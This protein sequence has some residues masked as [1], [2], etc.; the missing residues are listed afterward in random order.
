MHRSASRPVIFDVRPK[1]AILKGFIV[2]LVAF[3]TVLILSVFSSGCTRNLWDGALRDDAHE[4]YN[5]PECTLFT[6]LP[7]SRIVISDHGYLFVSDIIIQGLQPSMATDFIKGA[8]V[9]GSVDS[10]KEMI[11]D[12][13]FDVKKVDQAKISPITD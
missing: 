13:R 1:Q 12:I 6:T 10:G 8:S 9:Y 2:K 11:F 3:I 5:N 7:D 4:S